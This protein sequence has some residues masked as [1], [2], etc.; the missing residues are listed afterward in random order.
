MFFL[1][2]GVSPNS[3]WISIDIGQELQLE[4][5]QEQE[6]EQELELE[7]ER[8]QDLKLELKS[9]DVIYSDVKCIDL[10]ILQKV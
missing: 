1:F 3:N 4:K 8:E 7:L 2:S 10:C 6:L 9:L 5:E